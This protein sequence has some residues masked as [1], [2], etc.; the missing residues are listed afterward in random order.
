VV[1]A[2]L[3]RALYLPVI[4]VVGLKLGCLNHAQLTA[5]AIAADRCELIGWIANR[6]DPSMDC[7]EENLATLRALLPAPCLGVL[8]HANAP[9]PHALAVHL[10]NAADA[11]RARA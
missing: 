3:V 10:R 2:D 4:L 6:V 8:P 11:L 7:A 5:R 9:D 1:Q